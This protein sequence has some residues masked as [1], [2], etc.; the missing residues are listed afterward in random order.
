[1]TVRLDEKLW[2]RLRI[3]LAQ[4]GK[5]LQDVFG[6]YVERYVEAKEKK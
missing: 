4:E 2:R 1:M 5:S 6:D 3:I